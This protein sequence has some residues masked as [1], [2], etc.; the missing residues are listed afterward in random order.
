MIEIITYHKKKNKKIIL[1]YFKIIRNEIRLQ[2]LALILVHQLTNTETN[3]DVKNK[4]TCCIIMYACTFK[5]ITL[6]F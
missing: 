4:C 3:H 2:R 5:C 6:E 1:C